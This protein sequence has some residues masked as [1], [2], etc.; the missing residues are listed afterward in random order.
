M[1]H[2][3]HFRDLCFHAD[4]LYESISFLIRSITICD[5]QETKYEST[6]VPFFLCFFA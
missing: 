1:D 5:F 3:N 4:R 6:L 2:E